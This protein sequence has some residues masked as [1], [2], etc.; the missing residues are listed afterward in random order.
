MN[1]AVPVLTAT[2][3]RQSTAK[4]TG[5]PDTGEPR[6]TQRAAFQD[7]RDCK[8]DLVSTEV[9]A[10]RWHV[11]TLA[12]LPAP[13]AWAWIDA[14]LVSAG[15][16]VSSLSMLLAAFEARRLDSSSEGSQAV[17]SSSSSAAAPSG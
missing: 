15:G 2:N 3:C 6:L 17:P 16:A 12:A 14:A 7:L 4:V 9:E 5:K 13:E 10:L 1:R 8:R 11:L